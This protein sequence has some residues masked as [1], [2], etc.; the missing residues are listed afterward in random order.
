MNTLF[1]ILTNGYRLTGLLF[2]A[3]LFGFMVYFGYCSASAGMSY[4]LTC[5]GVTLVI[6]YTFIILLPNI[7]ILSDRS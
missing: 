5:V 2:T 6:T 4:Y 3:G 7:L 1:K